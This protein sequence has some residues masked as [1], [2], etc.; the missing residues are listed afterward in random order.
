MQV[1]IGYTLFSACSVIANHEQLIFSCECVLQEGIRILHFHPTS[2][3]FKTH[4]YNFF[5]SEIHEQTLTKLRQ[6]LTQIGQDEWMYKPIDQI[7][8]F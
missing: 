8:G 7:I 1:V 2:Y 6:E 5:I 4:F 3:R